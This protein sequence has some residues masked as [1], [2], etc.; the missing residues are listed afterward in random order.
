MP[1]ISGAA[2]EIDNQLAGIERDVELLLNITPVN[3]AQAGTDC[4]P[5]G[6]AHPPMLQCRRLS[7]DRGVLRRRLYELAIERVEE[8]ALAE[9]LREKRDEITR[10]ITLLSDRDTWRFLYGSLSLFGEV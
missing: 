10:Q 9:L 1:N 4:E 5:S 8:P 3:A 2:V 7:F 6:F